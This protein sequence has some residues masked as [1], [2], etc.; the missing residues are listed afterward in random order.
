MV[1]QHGLRLAANLI[2]S[3]FGDLVGVRP[4]LPLYP[5]LPSSFSDFSTLMSSLRA[6]RRF[7]SVSSAVGRSPSMRSSDSPSFPR[8]RSRTA[9]LSSSSTAVFRPSPFHDP[10][11]TLSFSIDRI[12]GQRRTWIY[13]DF[14]IGFI[15]FSCFWRD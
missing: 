2:T 11:R 8:R 3:H 4:S 5:P 14:L 15:G 13:Y 6:Y 10:V 1:S 7:A 9:F 12:R